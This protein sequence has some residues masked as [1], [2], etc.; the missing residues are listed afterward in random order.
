MQHSQ[1]GRNESGIWQAI[2]AAERK[3]A[4]HL[5]KTKYMKTSP[6]EVITK[7]SPEQRKQFLK[8]C[9][10][11]PITKQIK[12]ILINSLDEFHKCLREQREAGVYDTNRTVYRGVKN[13]RKHKLIPKIGRPIR[14][15]GNK[16]A[17]QEKEMLRMFQE[18][19]PFYSTS[20]S[21][22]GN[23]WESLFF[24]QHY[25]LPTRLLD[26]TRNPLV[27]LYF[28]VA[29]KYM[30]DSAVYVLK[31]NKKSFEWRECNCSPLDCKNFGDSD[32]AKVIPP[33]FS[34]RIVA[35]S[36]LFTIHAK[37]ETALDASHVDCIIIPK[38][39]RRSFKIMLYQYG[40]HE[41]SIK[42]GFDSLCSHLFW[43]RTDDHAPH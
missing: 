35:Q 31:D 14:W 25:G 23:K 1:D 24:A 37:P 18:R 8:R 4:F 34:E 10:D 16:R 22:I 11:L 32:F 42:P 27:A 30:G 2:N 40:V 20:T 7:L 12:P 26:W 41:A 17:T 33:S 5:A 38:E 39:L 21:F 36:G 9:E 6:D 3:T 15:K 13:V 28:A 19:A 29:T 43:L